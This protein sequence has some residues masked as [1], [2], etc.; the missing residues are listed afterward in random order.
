MYLMTHDGK[1]EKKVFT[2][3]DHLGKPE[4]VFLQD[5]ILRRSNELWLVF[6]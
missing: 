3:F 6:S 5:E 4:P 2:L 1:L